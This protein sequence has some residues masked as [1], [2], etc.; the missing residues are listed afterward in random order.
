MFCEFDATGRLTAP[1]RFLTTPT[2]QY[3]IL[4]AAMKSPNP[5]VSRKISV[6][7]CLFSY[8]DGRRQCRT[9]RQSGHPHF[10]FFHARKEA[11]A[12]AADQAGRE[13]SAL[14]SGSYLSACDLS[15]A[16]ARLCAATAQG[17]IKP[18]T[19]ATLAYLGQTLVQ[20]IQIAE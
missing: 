5:N 7:R 16:L 1:A 2:P 19:A 8:S 13:V 6:S 11:Q 15:S 14:L 20:S 18:R 10:C 9:P 12:R 4:V 3:F 17:Q